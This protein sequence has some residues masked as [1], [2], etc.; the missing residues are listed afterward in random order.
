MSV[1]GSQNLCLYTGSR[2]RGT[3]AVTDASRA[4]GAA[5]AIL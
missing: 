3:S 5:A 2:E 4:F 1:P